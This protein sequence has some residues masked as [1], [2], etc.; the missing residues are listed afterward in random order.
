MNYDIVLD[1]KLRHNYDAKCGEK[2]I[3]I[4]ATMQ[5]A[6]TFKNCDGYYLGLE[7]H[8]DGSFKEIYNGTAKY[9]HENYKHRKDIGVKL[10]RFKNKELIALSEKIDKQE[11]IYEKN[12]I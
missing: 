12:I 4:K 11:K 7:I 2:E 6:L 3:Q 9:I 1:K 8:P 5:D 10:L